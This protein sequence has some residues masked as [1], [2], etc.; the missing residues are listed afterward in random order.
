MANAAVNDIA[1]GTAAGVVSVLACHPLD[2]LRVRMQTAPS[3]RFTGVFDVLS[4]TV[5]R[6][7]V[8]ALY[9]GLSMPLLAQGVQK[10]TMFYSFGAARRWMIERGAAGA[11]G[12]LP[13]ACVAL[14]GSFAGMCN[15]V[16]ASP[17]ELVR[18][19]LQVQYARHASEAQYRGPIDAARQIVSTA[20]ARSLWLGLGPMML[21]DA[22][23]LAA[24]YG[25][26]ELVRRAL[27]PPPPPGA[28]GVAP[29]QQ[30]GFVWKT[31][32]SGASGGVAFWVCAFPQD[33]IKNVIQT[34]GMDMRMQG[35]SPIPSVAA[36]AGGVAAAAA[37]TTTATVAAAPST[38]GFFATGAR[39]V[40][41][42]G[43]RR[44]WRGF[45]I[46]AARGIPGA[47]STFLTYQL[48]INYLNEQQ[49]R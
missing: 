46:A 28:P 18:N 8:R 45:P 6:E 1:A 44:L 40:R 4:T 16:V 24:W 42:E 38:E 5:R 13:I 2:T 19:R 30:Q 17:F 41:E 47:S 25:T 21:R 7:G 29:G 9:K 33:T 35:H 37:T 15:A 22:P 31:L 10:A 11:G 43:W 49:Q 32:L 36:S 39:L 20:G 12:P 14:C 23:G 34:R 27:L 48:V 26:F 3:G